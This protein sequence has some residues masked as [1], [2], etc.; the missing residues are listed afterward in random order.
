MR[1]ACL[2]AVALVLAACGG[3]A[4]PRLDNG[5]TGAPAPPDGGMRAGHAGNL[6]AQWANAPRGTVRVPERDATPPRAL[7]GLE[8][9]T[10]KPVV[11]D[12]PVRAAPAP[13][14]ALARPELG[15]R[16]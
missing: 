9:G 6:E 13:A 5:D 10:G 12:S 4:P 11:H 16:S 15:G 14:V 7:L 1:R 8:T 3:S 2:A